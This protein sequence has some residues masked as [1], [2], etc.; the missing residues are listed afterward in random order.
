MIKINCIYSKEATHVKQ[1]LKKIRGFDIVNYMDIMNKLTKNDVYSNEPSDLIINSHIIRLL[2]K[3]IIEK[4]VK[5]IYYVISNLEHETI[6]N[7]KE[8]INSLS[9]DEIEYTV[10]IKD[11]SE[12]NNIHFMFDNVYEMVI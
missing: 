8:Y 6:Y 12:Y 5:I 2:E 9:D 1:F 7:L 11:K 4:N 3:M 10:F